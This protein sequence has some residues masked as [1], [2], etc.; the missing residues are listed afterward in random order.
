MPL[1]TPILDDRT[2]QQLRD[3]LVGRIPVYTPEWTDLHPGDPGIAL[4]ELFAY[5]GE[6]LL[7]RFNQLPDAARMAFLRLLDI[8]LDPAGV[9]QG[10]VQFAVKGKGPGEVLVPQ[11]ST[12]RAGKV[13]Y[14]TSIEVVAQPVEMIAATRMPAPL[15]TDEELRARAESAVQALALTADQ[16]PAY[17]E[18]R[19]LAADTTDPT[20]Q[21][22]DPAESVDATLWLAILRRE[23][24]DVAPDLRGRL[25]TIG[26]LPD[27]DVPSMTDVDV[28]PGDGAGPPSPPL[29]WRISAPGNGSDAVHYE[30]VKVLGDTTAALTKAGAI[31]LSLPANLGMGL[32]DD[33]ALT[34]TGGLPPTFEDDRDGRIIAWLQATRPDQIATPIVRVGWIGVNATPV[35][36][37]QDAPAELLGIG[38]AEA[39]QRYRLVHPGVRLGSL[40]LDVEEAG[41]WVRWDEIDDLSA[42]PAGRHYQLD[43]ESSEVRFG[44]GVRGRAPQ[45]GERIR[46]L[47]Y[48]YGGGAEGNVAPKAIDKC[49]VAGVEVANPWPTSG[50]S[51]PEALADAIERIPAELRRRDRAVT[52]SDFAELAMRTPGAA[53]ARA[54]CLPL[55]DPHVPTVERPGAVS[56]VVWPQRDRRHPSAPRPDRATL[57][58]VCRYLDQRRLVTTELFVI[59]PTYR[60][61][62]VAVGVHVKPDHGI[63]AVRRWV[64]LVLR[65]YLAPVPP[66]GPEGRGWPL[67]RRVHGPELEAAAL[68]VDGVEYLEGLRLSVEV[69]G[70]DGPFWQEVDNPPTV[71]LEP[72]EVPEL[73]A[74]TV[75]TGP[76]LPPGVEPEPPSDQRVPVPIPVPRMVC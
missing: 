10:V 11:D 29:V 42:S 65:Q 70:A 76:P 67:G 12:V 20:A 48:R 28:C 4:L 66:Y 19:T 25:L 46:V 34:G 2:Y 18:V 44:D 53:L 9:A 35:M 64:E 68:Q 51:A 1:L 61:I 40:A 72:Y 38:T 43:A 32:P 55:F 62:A 49:D 73:T 54:E 50:G 24:D 47:S 17:Y 8:P 23:N 37:E 22:L 69:T 36:Q 5:L 31:T 15:P 14:T 52:R 74:I 71:E 21:P 16:T 6:H 75:V 30:T 3:E 56:V 60:R 27:S 63:E 33:P 57:A 26:Y 45:L 41:M 59:P 39:G 13:V 58:S 7:Y